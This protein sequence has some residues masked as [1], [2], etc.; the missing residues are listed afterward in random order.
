MNQNIQLADRLN[1]RIFL[2]RSGLGA[3]AIPFLTQGGSVLGGEARGE[4]PGLP[5]HPAK[6]KRIIYLFQSGAPSQMDLFDPKPVMEKHRGENLPDSIR[7][8]QRLTTMTSGQ[9]TFPSLHR[10]LN[11]NP[12]G[13]RE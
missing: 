9:S 7:Q 6:A 2:G 11:S 8:G 4:I 10:S 1:R 13:N 12:V 5:H 3:M